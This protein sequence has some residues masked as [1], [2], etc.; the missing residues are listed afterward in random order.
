MSPSLK[1]PFL[2]QPGTRHFPW[3]WEAIF[4][5]LR[6]RGYQVPGLPRL[7]SKFEVSFSSQLQQLSETLSWNVKWGL[8][9]HTN[10]S[11]SPV[12]GLPN[13]YKVLGSVPS[14]AENQNKKKWDFVKVANDEKTETTWLL[15]GV[16]EAGMVVYD[17]HP[18]TQETQKFR[19]SQGKKTLVTYKK[20]KKS[21]WSYRGNISFC[22]MLCYSQGLI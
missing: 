5:R 16:F 15:K 12:K 2:L 18:H 21:A 3:H 4:K 14:T 20:K 19:A 22:L 6:W 1:V 17:H 9:I 8:R 7:Q 11:L 13:M 10:K